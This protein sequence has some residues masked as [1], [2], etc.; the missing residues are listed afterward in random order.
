[1][2]WKELTLEI[3]AVAFTSVILLGLNNDNI[4]LLYP[5]YVYSFYCSNEVNI[6]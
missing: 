6:I 1:M 2:A 4:S 3:W 5:L